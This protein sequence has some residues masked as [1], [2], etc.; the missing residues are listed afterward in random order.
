MNA[1]SLLGV[2]SLG[3]SK[4][5]SITL[6]A[7]GADE[8][9]AIEGLAALVGG[10]AA[11]IGTRLHLAILAL[12]FGVPFF[13]FRDDRKL[14]ALYR[15]LEQ[16]KRKNPAFHRIDPADTEK[17]AQAIAAAASK[18]KEAILSLAKELRARE[19]PLK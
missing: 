17:A 3:I 4:G 2:L 18:E 19:E 13:S 9:D 14:D 15:D 7:D 12:R 1:K 6:I 16:I 11:A 8:A 10:A 5:S